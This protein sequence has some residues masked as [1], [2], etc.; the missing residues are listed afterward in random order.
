MFVAQ[1]TDLHLLPPGKPASDANAR[2]FDA[3]LD[4]LRGLLRQP[5]LYLV[6]G[7]IADGGDVASY[8]AFLRAMRRVD[9]PWL[10]LMGNHDLGDNFALALAEEPGGAFNGSGSCRLGRWRVLCIDTSLP[11]LEGGYFDDARAA[12]LDAA[13]AA[14]CDTPTVIAM[15]H[16]P[17]ASGVGWI[18]PDEAAEWIAR[19]ASVVT[20]FGQVRHIVCGHAHMAVMTQ[21]HGIPLSISPA[22]AP[23]LWPEA[24]PFD[25]DR[26]DG[27]VMVVDGQ[28]GFALH[29]LGQDRVTTTFAAPSVGQVWLR[30]DRAHE[31][32]VMAVG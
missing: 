20:R 8:R 5:D 30:H 27:R 9:R 17:V 16:P 18:D 22:T 11:G 10:C 15:H 4:T 29:H 25:A 31:R 3:C 28:P 2:R 24:A 21:F 7:D 12:A 13:L 19:F 14:D 23:Q 6:T 32:D 26:P 1:L